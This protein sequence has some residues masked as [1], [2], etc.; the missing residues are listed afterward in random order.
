[1]L[2]QKLELPQF[3][4]SSEAQHLRLLLLLPRH[5]LYRKTNIECKQ[6][7]ILT[8]NYRKLLNQLYAFVVVVDYVGDGVM[9]DVCVR[10]TRLMLRVMI[11]CSLP[12][13]ALN[14]NI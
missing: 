7:Q 6:E 12:A 14:S 13:R 2:S 1:M 3:L 11:S 8:L 4:K 10:I 5:Q 9:C